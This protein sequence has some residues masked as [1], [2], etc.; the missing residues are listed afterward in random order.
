MLKWPILV[1]LARP[2]LVA[3][4]GA[5]AGQLVVLAGAPPADQACVERVISGLLSNSLQI[6]GLSPGL[7]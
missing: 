4:T 5:V 2:A 7:N 3:L 6:L 1:A